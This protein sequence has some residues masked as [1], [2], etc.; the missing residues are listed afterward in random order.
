M[1][2]TKLWADNKKIITTTV[3]VVVTVLLVLKFFD[4]IFL[5]GTVA[6]IA[7]AAVLGWNHLSK[8]HGGPLG[9][10]NALLTELGIKP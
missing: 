2:L 4:Y 9:V 10:W 6:A 7:I 1:E 8:K 3:L 5:T